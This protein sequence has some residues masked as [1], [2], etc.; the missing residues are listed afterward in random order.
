MYFAV[1]CLDKPDYY[2]V[3][4]EI[5]PAH[6]DFLKANADR[7]KIAGPFLSDDGAS[8]VGSLLIFDVEDRATLDSLLDADPYTKAGLFESVTVRPWRWAIGNPG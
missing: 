5:R 4:A 6:L 7:V 8:M 3:R 1:T 2:Y